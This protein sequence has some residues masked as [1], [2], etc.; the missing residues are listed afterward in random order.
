MLAKTVLAPTVLAQA[1]LV[2]VPLLV[3]GTACAQSIGNVKG[4][5]LVNHGTGFLPV[6]A[7]TPLRIG[8]TVMARPGGS[9]T[10]RYADGCKV[11]VIPG[12][13]LTL[14]NISPCSIVNAVDPSTDTPVAQQTNT[15]NTGTAPPPVPVP[16]LVGLGTIAA[17]GAIGGTIA[18]TN[19]NNE[20][21]AS[22]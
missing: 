9:A 2:L 17:I 1:V 22:P 12:T 13:V 19:Q 7:P 15:G 11:D 8:D 21:P 5:V 18:I 16:A 6:T 20:Q 14:E 10:L 3:A 4:S